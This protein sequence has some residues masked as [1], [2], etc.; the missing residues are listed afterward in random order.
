M[1]QIHSKTKLVY[2]IRQM[3]L[4]ILFM[5]HEVISIQL[6]KMFSNHSNI[7]NYD[8]IERDYV[9]EVKISHMKFQD[10][11]KVVCLH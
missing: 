3:I 1:E 4:I 2:F 8:N 11:E 5:E 9:S 10:L 7:S 6:L